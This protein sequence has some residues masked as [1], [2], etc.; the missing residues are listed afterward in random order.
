MRKISLY[1]QAALYIMA[2]FMHFVTPG[3]YLS[4]MPP[5]IPESWH[6]FLVIL[7]GI[8]ELL[9]GIGLLFRATRKWA[10]LGVI[11]LLVAVFPANIYMAIEHEKLGVNVVLAYGRLPLQ[12]LLM[13]WAWTFFRKPA[14]NRS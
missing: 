11:L 4:I 13:W 3:V 2:G 1:I 12:L 14:L 10:A 5:A 7:S 8:F 6:F 9:L